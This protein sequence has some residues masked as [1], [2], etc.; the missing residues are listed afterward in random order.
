MA[1]PAPLLPPPPP[2]PT[3]LLGSR[4]RLQPADGKARPAPS[5]EGTVVAVAPKVLTTAAAALAA[6]HLWILDV[7]T[8][9]TGAIHRIS[10]DLRACA[11]GAPQTTRIPPDYHWTRC[12]LT[13]V[14]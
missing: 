10:Y 6:P 1:A 7:R 3:H 11:A 12:H 2:A 4:I 9:A 8:D 13:V 14:A 5:L